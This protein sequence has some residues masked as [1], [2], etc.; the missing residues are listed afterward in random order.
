M[1]TIWIVGFSPVDSQA[2]VGGFDW[3]KTRDAAVKRMLRHLE[4][5]GHDLTL[6][7]YKVPGAWADDDINECLLDH[8]VIYELD[9][10]GGG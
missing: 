8:P 9:Y 7:E 5:S 4:S 3:Y 1:K 6:R 10:S 2:S